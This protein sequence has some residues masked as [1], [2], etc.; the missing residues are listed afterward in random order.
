LK[1]EDIADPKLYRAYWSLILGDLCRQL[2]IP[3]TEKIKLQ[4]HKEFKDYLGYISTAG[5]SSEEYK[6]FLFQVLA[7]CSVE[8]GLFVRS[9]KKQ[10]IGIADYNLEDCWEF[11]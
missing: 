1:D 11:L 7:T 10:P 4:L 6:L 5:M 9:S 8:L 2:Y 3:H